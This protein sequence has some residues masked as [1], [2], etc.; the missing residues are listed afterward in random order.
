MDDGDKKRSEP[1]DE[2]GSSHT[3]IYVSGNYIQ[4]DQTTV[5][6]ISDSDGIAVG[7]DASSDVS[8]GAQPVQAGGGDAAGREL[9]GRDIYKRIME[10][11]NLAEIENLCY[12]LGVEFEDLGG[13]GK[14]GKARELV[15]YMERRGRLGELDAMATSLR[16]G[17]G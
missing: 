6:N 11:F 8:K 15:K 9:D 13:T 7:K 3:T 4:G 12:Q 16:G 10:G 2:K 1:A 14:S 5:G 17:D